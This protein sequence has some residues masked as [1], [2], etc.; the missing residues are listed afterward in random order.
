MAQSFRRGIESLY[1]FTSGDSK[2][3]N[4]SRYG[5]KLMSNKGKGVPT[6]FEGDVITLKNWSDNDGMGFL[7]PDGKVEPREPSMDQF[8]PPEFLLRFL[9]CD[10]SAPYFSVPTSGL[11]LSNY[12]HGAFSLLSVK[13]FG[14][15]STVENVPG[16]IST[17][18]PA[19]SSGEI[20]RESLTGETPP[21]VEW[22]RADNFEGR[23][24]FISQVYR[25]ATYEIRIKYSSTSGGRV[26]IEA[27][28]GNI[29]AVYTT[30]DVDK[31][32]DFSWSES[33]NIVVD[34]DAKYPLALSIIIT[35]P[36]V[37]SFRINK[38][39]LRPNEFW[40]CT[41]NNISSVDMSNK[42][43]SLSRPDS[44]K[45]VNNYSV[46]SFGFTSK[47]IIGGMSILPPLTPFNEYME[48][49]VSSLA[50]MLGDDKILYVV[51]T[52]KMK[53]VRKTTTSREF[54]GISSKF[55]IR[56]MCHTGVVT[57][58]GVYVFFAGNIGDSGPRNIQ[59][60]VVYNLNTNKIAE[61]S[62]DIGIS[63]SIR[64]F[65]LPVQFQ[66]PP[67]PDDLSTLEKAKASLVDTSV[68]GM[69]TFSSERPDL[70]MVFTANGNIWLSRMDRILYAKPPIF[71]IKVLDGPFDGTFLSSIHSGNRINPESVVR[72]SDVDGKTTDKL[73]FPM[74]LYSPKNSNRFKWGDPCLL[75]ALDDCNGPF[76]K[77]VLKRTSNGVTL[78]PIDINKL[79]ET[80]F[81][82]IKR[83]IIWSIM[84]P[85]GRIPPWP[86]GP[87]NINYSQ[88]S[89]VFK[90]N[91]EL[92]AGTRKKYG[93]ISISNSTYNCGDITGIMESSLEFKTTQKKKAIE[94]MSK[95]FGEDV[96]K[97][98]VNAHMGVVEN[99][100]EI[101]EKDEPIVTYETVTKDYWENLPPGPDLPP[102]E[103]V[104]IIRR[105]TWSSSRKNRLLQFSV[106]FCMAVILIF[107]L[108]VL[109]ILE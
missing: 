92:S 65:D 105:Y 98:A 106:V 46:E 73:N 21:V 99:D 13:I 39:C 15:E 101:E 63:Q 97:N 53:I 37:S 24:I 85:F 57:Q 58:D 23:A 76:Q 8:L 35:T 49:N 80:D 107:V 11:P 5:D 41:G 71:S 67:I 87:P 70:L 31:S 10:P 77:T 18:N 32:D 50:Y 88:L 66:P 52:F 38:I 27:R 54:N 30:I 103:N 1:W 74:F 79:K 61:G 17:M 9:P 84:P 91:C 7:R 26:N 6:I 28:I 60:G 102:I 69:S 34:S 83:S 95:E 51:D 36:S 93:K 44:G 82:D 20:P 19:N 22:L 96:A 55:N 47:K 12:V 59:K 94:N 42:Q 56:S 72:I 86:G 4:Y 75:L 29:K 78:E 64:V 14:L 48:G 109:Y 3:R 40:I 45:N 81:S 43:Y 90:S 68:V 62:T 16:S 108:V 100:E 89:S 2:V 25:K 33:G 104:N